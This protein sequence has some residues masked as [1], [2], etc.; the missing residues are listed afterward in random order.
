[1]LDPTDNENGRAIH[2]LNEKLAVD[3]RVSLSLVPLA[4]GVSLVRRR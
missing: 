2:A 1:V 4:D 3:D